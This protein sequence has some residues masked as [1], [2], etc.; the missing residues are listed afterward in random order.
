MIKSTTIVGL[1]GSLRKAS[2]NTKLLKYIEKE[3]KLKDG[4]KHFSFGNINLPLYNDDLE[5]EAGIPE[6]VIKLGETLSR[7]SGIIISTPEYNKGISGALK[8]SFD[9]MSRLKPNPFTSKTIAIVSATDGRSGG[10]R[11]QYML[12]M[13]LTPFDCKIIQTPE[14][15]IGHSSKAFNGDG[16]LNDENSQASDPEEGVVVTRVTPGS[17][18]SGKIMRGDIITDVIV[19]GD[20]KPVIDIDSFEEI[21][22]SLSSGDKIALVGR[23]SGNR[24]FVAI[25]VD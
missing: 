18:A 23:R 13:C 2:S 16:D 10:E 17:S 25:T 7:A 6:T 21:V 15:L 3:I 9:W 1:S 19:S 12:R 11:S 22:D 8:N 20:R 24:F 4:D 5:K 14:V